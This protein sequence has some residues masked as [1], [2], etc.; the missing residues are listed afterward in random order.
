MKALPDY[1]NIDKSLIYVIQKITGDSTANIVN[2]FCTLS[3]SIVEDALLKNKK[4]KKYVSKTMKWTYEDS[5]VPFALSVFYSTHGQHFSATVKFGS[6]II[7][8]REK[9]VMDLIDRQADYSIGLEGAEPVANVAEPIKRAPIA[10]KK[11]LKN[12]LKSKDVS[13]NVK[14]L[15]QE[16]ILKFNLQQNEV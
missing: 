14:D 9:D 3:R 16:L 7:R 12:D 4:G 1:I 6:K 2:Y 15:P 10:I 8:L 11:Q 13:I 5:C